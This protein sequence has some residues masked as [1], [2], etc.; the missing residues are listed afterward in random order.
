[1]FC[2]CLLTNIGCNRSHRIGVSWCLCSHQNA[3]NMYSSE[4]PAFSREFP[5]IAKEPLSKPLIQLARVIKIVIRHKFSVQ[6]KN[7][8]L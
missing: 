4:K 8:P 5:F 7:K 2:Q 3:E 6:G 1:M